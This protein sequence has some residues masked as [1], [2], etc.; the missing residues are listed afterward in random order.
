MFFLIT[1]AVTTLPLQETTQ[2]LVVTA[3]PFPSPKHELPVMTQPLPM[4]QQ[5][6]L[7][8]QEGLAHIHLDVGTTTAS[9]PSSI[10]GKDY[11]FSHYLNFISEIGDV[12]CIFLCLFPD[13]LN[14]Q[15]RTGTKPSFSSERNEETSSFQ[16][17]PC[18]GKATFSV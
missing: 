16:I 8:S 15:S 2:G 4:P 17:L 7:A 18:S 6:L 3:H 1:F 9:G 5:D 10:I 11:C 12:M 13:N 14:V